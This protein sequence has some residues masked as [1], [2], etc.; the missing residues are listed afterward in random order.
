MQ[1]KFKFWMNWFGKEYSD[2]ALHHGDFF[3]PEFE[4]DIK[5]AE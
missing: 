4:K 1:K 3:N 5:K 2:F